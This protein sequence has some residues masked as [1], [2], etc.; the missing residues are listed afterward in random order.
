MV[1]ALWV[2]LFAYALL[3]GFLAYA[4][5]KH[6]WWRLKIGIKL[7][8]VPAFLFFGVLDVAFNLT[9]GSLLF[10]D[11]PR[12]LTFSQRCSRHLYDLGWRGRVAGA[13]SV[14]LNA[15]DPGH[16]R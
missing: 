4:A 3:L 11:V 16:I 14:P 15:I 1:T 2:A 9:F 8:L 13:F 10:L 6:A 5:A 7:L 12:E